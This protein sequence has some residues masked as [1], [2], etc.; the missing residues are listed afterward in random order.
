[1][2]RGIFSEHGVKINVVGR[3]HL[4]PPVVKGELVE[5]EELTKN[6]NR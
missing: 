2:A 6:N 3:I 1:V 5:A 4:L